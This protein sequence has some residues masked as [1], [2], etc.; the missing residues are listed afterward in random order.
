MD[1]PTVSPASQPTP[2]RPEVVSAS[3]LLCGKGVLLIE[4]AGERYQLRLT[5]NGKLIL[6]K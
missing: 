1:K 6:T 4:H 5:K 3:L 2:P